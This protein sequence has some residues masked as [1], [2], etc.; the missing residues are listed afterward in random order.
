M[1]SSCARVLCL[2]LKPCSGV[3]PSPTCGWMRPFLCGGPV[4]SQEVAL[5]DCC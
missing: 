4:L 2:W 5:L 3:L 1:A